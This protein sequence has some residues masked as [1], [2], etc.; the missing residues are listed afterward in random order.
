M[1]VS[2]PRMVCPGQTWHLALPSLAGG[3]EPQSCRSIWQNA[4]GEVLGCSQI[5]RQH[6]AVRRLGCES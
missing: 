5:G 4:L 1:G 2:G 3:F 6:P